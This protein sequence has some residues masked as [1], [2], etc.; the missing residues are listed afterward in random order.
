MWD[1]V[2]YVQFAEGI[3]VLHVGCAVG[4]VL[5]VGY[6]VGMVVVYVSCAV[7]MVLYVGCAVGMVLYAGID[8]WDMVL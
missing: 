3:V 1:M 8:M 4:M 7:G 6:A 5:H 2:L